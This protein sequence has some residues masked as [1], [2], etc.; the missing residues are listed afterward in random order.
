[1]PRVSKYS[2]AS[3]TPQIDPPNPLSQQQHM[4]SLLSSALTDLTNRLLIAQRLTTELSLLTSSILSG[5]RSL[6]NMPLPHRD[7]T[8][9]EL[10]FLS[11]SKSLTAII[12]SL[13]SHCSTSAGLI[14]SWTT[15]VPSSCL[16]TKQR[17][18]LDLYGLNSGTSDPSSPDTSGEPQN[19]IF[20]LLEQSYGGSRYSSRSVTPKKRSSTVRSG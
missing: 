4:D 11:R 2:G 17:R 3:S 1:M 10:S 12:Q 20:R 15:T 14:K 9:L 16:T 8:D 5:I 6:E 18:L 7:R 13:E 19:H